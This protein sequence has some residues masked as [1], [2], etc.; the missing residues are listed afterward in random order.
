MARL[1]AM[2]VQQPPYIAFSETLIANEK[3]KNENSRYENVCNVR[4]FAVFNGIDFPEFMDLP[5]IFHCIESYNN[6]RKFTLLHKICQLYKEFQYF[7]SD[8]WWGSDI[9]ILL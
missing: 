6:Y 3:K 7:S 5:D 8:T 2:H 4:R 1:C 9:N